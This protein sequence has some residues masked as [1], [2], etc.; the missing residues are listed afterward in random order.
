MVT[1]FEK[2]VKAFLKRN[3]LKFF[4]GKIAS[5]I[6]TFSISHRKKAHLQTKSQS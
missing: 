5:F 1:D 3:Y 4:I 2:V 6:K